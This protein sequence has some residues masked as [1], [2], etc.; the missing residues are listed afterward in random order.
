MLK[1]NPENSYT[2]CRSQLKYFTNNLLDVQKLAS[3]VAL[4]VLF[5]SIFMLFIVVICYG[6][7]LHLPKQCLQGCFFDLVGYSD[8]CS[9]SLVHQI[10]A[11][12]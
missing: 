4:F 8:F 3:R 9:N 1:Q 10:I 12:V 7:D 5:I 6:R 2:V 11:V